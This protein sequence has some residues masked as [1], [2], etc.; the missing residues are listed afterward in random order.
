MM[1]VLTCS[2]EDTLTMAT[3]IKENMELGP[4]YSF[5]GLVHYP[6]DRKYGGMEAGMVLENVLRVLHLI[7]REHLE[8]WSKLL[9]PKV[10]PLVTHF[11]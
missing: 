4:T 5:G 9:K 3:T 11:Q 8:S 2:K 1:P 6:H 10:Q 7:S